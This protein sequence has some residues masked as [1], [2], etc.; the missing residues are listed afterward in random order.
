[1]YT[2]KSAIKYSRQFLKECES[3]SI[4]IDRAIIF[5]SALSGKLHEYSDI[6]IALF[7]NNFTENILDNLDLIGMINI[8]FP[9][10]D[11][12]TYPSVYYESSGLLLDEIK[13]HGL[14]ISAG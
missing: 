3:L 4:K 11:V 1:M 8:R 6:D 7:S 10:L 14:D 12:H 9:D 5:G 2:R 13:K